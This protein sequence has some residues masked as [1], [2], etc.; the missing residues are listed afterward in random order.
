M[1]RST[2]KRSGHTRLCPGAV[3]LTFT[4]ADTT[5]GHPT[6]PGPKS[7]H[8]LDTRHT[9]PTGRRHPRDSPLLEITCGNH[10][11][12]RQGHAMHCLVLRS[13]AARR[14]SVGINGTRRARCRQRSHRKILVYDA[15][16]VRPHPPTPYRDRQLVKDGIT[17]RRS[18][19][20]R[21]FVWSQTRTLMTGSFESTPA[22]PFRMATTTL[23]ARGYRK[24]DLYKAVQSHCPK[25]RG[26][27][28]LTCAGHLVRVRV[29][30]QFWTLEHMTV[31]SQ[32]AFGTQDSIT[33][34]PWS[35]GNTM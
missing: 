10:R 15:S 28:Y 9:Q 13:P 6:F 31:G 5:A 4:V 33:S 30:F 35:L 14:W 24:K 34:Q 2:T 32:I 17:P 21:L 22:A 23:T 20:L 12:R 11:P 18:H 25:L 8:I 19:L 1:T 3:P 27:T 7:C 26:I 29:H 16:G